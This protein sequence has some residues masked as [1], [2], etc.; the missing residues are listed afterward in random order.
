VDWTPSPYRT[1]ALTPSGKATVTCVP[2]Q[3]IAWMPFLTPGLRTDLRRRLRGLGGLVKLPES[4]EG[5]LLLFRLLRLFFSSEATLP[6][7]ASTRSRMA[8]D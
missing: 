6:S 1:G 8:R 7:S 2:P 4:E 5:G 3:G